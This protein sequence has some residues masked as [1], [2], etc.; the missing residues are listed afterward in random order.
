MIPGMAQTKPPFRMLGSAMSDFNM[1]SLK[2]L[3]LTC[4]GGRQ[5][6]TFR[7]RDPKEMTLTQFRLFMQ[8]QFHA[9]YKMLPVVNRV[10]EEL[11]VDGGGTLSWSVRLM[12][13]VLTNSATYIDNGAQELFFGLE[14]IIGGPIEKRAA[15]YF[16]VYDI[17]GSGMV[18]IAEVEQ[19]MV[20]AG[21]SGKSRADRLANVTRVMRKLDQDGDGT[22][23]ESEFV[24]AC[25]LDPSM[26]ECFGTLFG[27]EETAKRGKMWWSRRSRK[28]V[29]DRCVT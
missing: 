22:V 7:S 21:R 13:V 24:R 9:S 10:F 5:T 1:N 19:L 18:D 27:N 2:A 23:T 28:E 8:E 16:R 14:L 11:D 4:Q 26:L 29:H 3:W 6:T 17:D 25:R 15:F 20:L 12:T